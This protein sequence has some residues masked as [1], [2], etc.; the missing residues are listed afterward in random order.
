MT[1]VLAKIKPRKATRQWSMQGFNYLLA[2]ALLNA[3]VWGGTLLYLRQLDP[4][5]VSRWGV[6]V[7]GADSNVNVSLPG[8]ASTSADTG[9]TNEFA[10]SDYVFI[11][12]SSDVIE[13]AAQQVGI[14]GEE[15]ETPD[16][17]V[18]NNTAVMT[19]A[20]EGS[21]PELAQR[22]ARALYT[23]HNQRVD[24]LREAEDNRRTL[25]DEVAL[26]RAR[27]RV[28]DAQEQLSNY[29]ANSE[30]N[31]NEQL[32][33]ITNGIESL[34]QLRSE[35]AVQA[36]G[37]SGR[38]D[39]LNSTADF[40]S[41]DV[42]DAYSLQSDPV[43]QQL[44]TTYGRVSAEFA[45]ISGQLGSQHPLVMDKRAE[46]DSAQASLQE[47]GAFL[48][49]RPVDQSTLVRISPLSID[50]QVAIVRGDLFREDLVSRAD[51]ERLVSQNQALVAEIDQMEGRL[52]QLSQ[53][54]FTV[55]Q[56][57]R[58]LQIAESIFASTLAR[59]D[60]NDKDIYS[61]Y[62]PIQ[63]VTEPSLPDEDDSVNP[64][65]QAVFLVGLGGSFVVTF[66][67]LLLWYE[68]RDRYVDPA[69]GYVTTES[70]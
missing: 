34:R 62:P 24:Q 64:S 9:R 44:F 38:I 37:L 23:A 33:N 25:E 30:F 65:T 27:T 1:D 58:N 52:N 70:V 51:R 19:F 17:T 16:I 31:S 20:I 2:G 3:L 66:G 32:Q 13:D 67:L 26:E 22:K 21:T 11:A 15:F 28:D 53:E 42:T 43:Y 5:Y 69:E 56:L 4:A 7:L 45:E 18:D 50:P 41:Q 63:L 68:K 48:L 49:G 36:D 55:D 47:R 14:D 54:K 61:I 40:E 60:L 46:L 35:Y 6:L 8:S 59:L 10:R 12:T 57:T 29:L 39:Q